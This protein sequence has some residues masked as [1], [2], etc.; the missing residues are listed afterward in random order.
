MALS[1]V[2]EGIRREEQGQVGSATEE[3]ALDSS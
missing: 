2:G 3:E 1:I